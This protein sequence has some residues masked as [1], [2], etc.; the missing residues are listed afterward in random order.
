VR[1]GQQRNAFK[2]AALGNPSQ[3]RADAEATS[4]A[5]K[6]SAYFRTRA[7]QRVHRM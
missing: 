7:L 6:R 4:R 3:D 2:A 1:T 5:P